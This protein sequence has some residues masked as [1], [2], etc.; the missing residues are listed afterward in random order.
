[1]SDL[2]FNGTWGFLSIVSIIVGYEAIH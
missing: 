2:V 1:V